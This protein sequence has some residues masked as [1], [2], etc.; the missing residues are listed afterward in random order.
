MR[1]ISL[2]TRKV[3]KPA[4]HVWTALEAPSRWPLEKKLGVHRNMPG[5]MLH[6]HQG[7]RK[8]AK[9]LSVRALP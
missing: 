9:S 3:N 5:S 2:S 7:E 8:G 6:Q 4:S 1:R